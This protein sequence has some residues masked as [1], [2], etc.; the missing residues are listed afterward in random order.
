[1]PPEFAE[2]TDFKVA[3]YNFLG[4]FQN[5]ISILVKYLKCASVSVMLSLEQIKKVSKPELHGSQL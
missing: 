5:C 3:F 1:M 4:S 2:A